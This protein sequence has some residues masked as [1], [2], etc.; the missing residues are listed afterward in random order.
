MKYYKIIE[1]NPHI[2]KILLLDADGE[3]ELSQFEFDKYW[4]SVAES[5]NTNV[6]NIGSDYHN[7]DKMNIIKANSPLLEFGDVVEINEEY[8]FLGF[9]YDYPRLKITN[10]EV[11]E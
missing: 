2:S 6:M 1:G 3:L 11:D 9:D 7:A 10:K 4:I 8:Y 5:S